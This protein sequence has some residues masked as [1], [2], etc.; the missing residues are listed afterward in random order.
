MSIQIQDN[1]RFP[2]FLIRED[3]QNKIGQHIMLSILRFTNQE[4]RH[5]TAF[6]HRKKKQFIQK[7][8][9]T[10]FDEHGVLNQYVYIK[11][12]FQTYL[13]TLSFSSIKY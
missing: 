13:L 7:A 2:T 5:S 11:H 10:L 1:T 3:E 8:L 12:I 9:D 6:S 4:G